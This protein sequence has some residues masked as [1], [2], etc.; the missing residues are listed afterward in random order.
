MKRTL[1]V[2]A[3]AMLAG[4]SSSGLPPD[5]GHST[6]GGQPASG[7]SV[8]TG[9]IV[10][11]D[12]GQPYPRAW[13]RFEVATSAVDSAEAHTVTDARGS[14]AIRLPAGQYQVSAGDDCDLNA[15]FDIVGRAREDMVIS[16]PET[17]H[18]DFVESPITQ[19]YVDYGA[20]A[21]N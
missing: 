13:V 1:I 5:P 14:F 6:T 16:V 15:Q 17:T 7:A 8:V 9:R 4:G 20:C 10:R 21:P 18:V 3:V 12:T 11:A 19:G 2:L